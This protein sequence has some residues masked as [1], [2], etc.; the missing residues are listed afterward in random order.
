MVTAEVCFKAFSC[1]KPQLDQVPSK[2]K[3]QP[4]S[5]QTVV[6]YSVLKME[7]ED[8]NIANAVTS[9]IL[10]VVMSSHET[11]QGANKCGMSLSDFSTVISRVIQ[12]KASTL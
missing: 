2:N 6:P 1:V 8:N 7:S 10:D 9:D 3:A 4:S 12:D 5:C 11:E